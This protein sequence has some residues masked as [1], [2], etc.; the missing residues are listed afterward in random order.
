MVEAIDGCEEGETSRL[1]HLRF[2]QVFTNRAGASK[3]S[4][5]ERTCTRDR[6]EGGQV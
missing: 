3:Q 6:T 1:G 4:Q 5:K 2:P